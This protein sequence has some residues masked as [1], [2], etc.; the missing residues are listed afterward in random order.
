M[1]IF[2]LVILVISITNYHVTM[3][4][5]K[6]IISSS[7]IF[8]TIA[9]NGDSHFQT[10]SRKKLFIVPKNYIY[11]TIWNY[12]TF[13]SILLRLNRQESIPSVNGI[14]NCCASGM[15]CDATG[16]FTQSFGSQFV[17]YGW[18]NN[19]NNSY[20]V[21]SC[22]NKSTSSTSKRSSV[23]TVNIIPTISDVTYLPN[24]SYL[25]VSGQ[26]FQSNEY[27]TEITINKEIGNNLEI[28]NLSQC[29]SCAIN[30]CPLDSICLN[31]YGQLSCYMYCNSPLDLSCP[32]GSTCQPLTIVSSSNYQNGQT[33]AVSLCAYNSFLSPYT[34]ELTCPYQPDLDFIKVQMP[35][36]SQKIYPDSGNNYEYGLSLTSGSNGVFKNINTINGFNR[37]YLNE[38]LPSTPWCSK[39]SDCF[40]GNICTIDTCTTDK[41]CHYSSV[42]GCNSTLSN[43]IDRTTPYTYDT[44]KLKSQSAKQLSFLTYIKKNG[45]D[46]YITNN[47]NYL[48]QTVVLS[49]K[50]LF[51]GTIVD[52]V[53]ILAGGALALPPV[54]ACIGN[55]V[56]AQVRWLYVM[57]F[58]VWYFYVYWDYMI[59]RNALAVWCCVL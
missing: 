37:N 38:N 46:T 8:Y 31:V 1:S 59:F 48:L 24:S 54:S 43:I 58:G 12:K 3:V 40:D 53:S 44:Y 47:N 51:F 19:D 7:S 2:T 14:K 42:T 36:L 34:S 49:F 26:K 10:C 32:C 41:Y 27:N 23:S 15:W 55:V 25:L 20:P 9:K 6:D 22:Y 39:N 33:T 57:V 29:R 11:S 28:C 4:N 13:Q 52:R 18:L 16:C 56:T 35:R 17:N 5:G 45:N 30:P 21:Y 50:M